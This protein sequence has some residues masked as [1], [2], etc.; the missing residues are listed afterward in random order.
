M[1]VQL[2]EALRYKPEGHGFDPRWCEWN[3][4]LTYSFRPHY[5][6]GVD[7]TSNRNEYQG[8]F[9]SGKGGRCV[10]VTL[11]H[12]CADCL[13]TC[14]LQPHGNLRACTG[15][16][17]PL[18]LSLSM[19]VYIYIYI[20][21]LYIKINLDFKLWISVQRPVVSDSDCTSDRLHSPAHAQ[22]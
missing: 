3:F 12:S 16:A 11:P 22:V 10:G 9:L 18:P 13:E 6:F 14:E 8:Y 17:V 4:S 7:S 5:G 1:G 2:V 15:I 20:Y 19:Y 21:I